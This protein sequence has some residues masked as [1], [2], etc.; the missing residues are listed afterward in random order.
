M[1][2]GTE[3]EGFEE[4][5]EETVL[6]FWCDSEDL[7]DFFLEWAFMD[8]D[9]AASDLDAVEDDVVGFGADF[10]EL[11]VGFQKVEVVLV[12]ACEGVV[13]GIPFLVFRGPFEEWEIDDP[14]EVERWVGGDEVAEGG[15]F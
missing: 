8:A 6:F 13:D 15:D 12:G 4:V 9:A 11:V 1:G 2:R 3:S 7:E 14:E 5:R 10:V